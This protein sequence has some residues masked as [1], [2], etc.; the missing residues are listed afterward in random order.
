MNYQQ[1]VSI[2]GDQAS[3][4]LDFKSTTFDPNLFTFPSQDKVL[5]YFKT[6][7]INPEVIQNLEKLYSHGRLGA[8]GYLSILPVDQ[9]VEHSAGASFAANPEYFDPQNL[10]HLAIDAGC[11]AFVST[12]GAIACLPASYSSKIPLIVKLNHNELLSYP[13]KAAEQMFTTAKQA[14]EVGAAGVGATI[15]FGSLTSDLEIQSVRQAFQEAHELGLFTVLWCYVRNSNFKIDG[16]NYETSADLTG[17][18]NYLGVSLGA[19]IIKQKLPT[20][21]GGFTALNTGN[22]SYGKLDEKIYSQ[23]TTDHPI[24]L[25]RY[26]LA[27]CFMGKIPL[28]SS[29]GDSYG[30]DDIKQAVISAVINKRAGG[31]GLIMGRKAF[32]KPFDE[33]VKIIQ[34]VQDVYLTSEISLA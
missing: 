1:I 5:S 28:I 31:S 22:S 26:Q 4:L 27:N 21:N 8:T 33:G 10:A 2:L 14:K 34:A 7:S 23:L 25:A 32:K 17:Q 30:G 19:D 20:C 24:D 12:Y 11:S 13:N 16:V 15:Y 9:G 6:R 29:G 18:A 3:Y